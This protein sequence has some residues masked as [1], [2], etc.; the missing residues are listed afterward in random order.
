MDNV[1]DDVFDELNN[2]VAVIQG[3]KANLQ[4]KVQQAFEQLCLLREARQNLQKDLEDKTVS[5]R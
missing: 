1:R 3:S 4:T 2:E 5:K